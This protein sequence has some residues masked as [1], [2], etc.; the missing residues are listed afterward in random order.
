MINKKTVIVLLAAVLFLP[1]QVFAGKFRVTPIKVYF[2]SGTKSS[3]INLINEAD[4]ELRVQLE[5]REW[6]QDMTGKDQ[7]SD[8][9]DLVFFPKVMILP[10]LSKRIIRLG[11]KNKPVDREKT[12][13]LFVQ[14]LPQRDKSEEGVKIAIAMRFGVP[15]FVTPSKVEAKGAIGDL[16]FSGGEVTVPVVNNGNVHM[17]INKISLKGFD[18]SNNEIY[19]KEL[20]GW[21]LL[22][23]K[24]R[25]YQSSIP[26]ETCPKLSSIVVG[27]MTDKLNLQGTI[28]VGEISCK[29]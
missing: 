1:G 15:V 20:N 19:Q 11:L 8:T 10:P 6:G 16:Q 2:D 12:Y 22:N 13:R 24:T 9:S 29:K 28:D 18:K 14:E 4:E 25:K 5:S 21:Y 23:N 26:E 3:V 17:M 7:Y 27:V